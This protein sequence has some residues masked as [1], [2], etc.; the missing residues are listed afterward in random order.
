[1]NEKQLIMFCTVSY[2][3][4][5]LVVMV[6]I[7]ILQDTSSIL[8]GAHSFIFS[9]GNLRKILEISSGIEECKVPA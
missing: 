6:K 1:M 3:D 2:K 9:Q 8:P 5:G 7:S 4:C